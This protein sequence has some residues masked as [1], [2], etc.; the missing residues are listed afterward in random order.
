M[1]AGVGQRGSALMIGVTTLRFRL[2]GPALPLVKDALPVGELFCRAALGALGN[3]FGGRLP[4]AFLAHESDGRPRRGAHDH[5]FYLAEDADGDGG[6]DHLIL[7]VPGGIAGDEAE[8]LT[9][10]QPLLGEGPLPQCRLVPDWAGAPG[11]EA[12]SR[13]LAPAAVWRS[14][15]PFVGNIHERDPILALTREMEKR[16]ILARAVRLAG[17]TGFVVTRQ[18]PCR[19][20]E[21]RSRH[22][23]AWFL[24]EFT[25]PVAGP[26]ALGFASHLGLGVFRGT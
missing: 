8:I 4:E 15:T 9:M 6:I 22:P 21:G 23:G 17:P 5:P 26:L 13:L 14:A 24:L 18:Q 19:F 16:Q 7:L 1:A 12:P 2:E 11:P 20:P 25:E 3:A 10:A